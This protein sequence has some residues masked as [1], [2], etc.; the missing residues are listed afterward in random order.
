[1]KK[2]ILFI[3]VSALLVVAVVGTIIGYSLWIISDDIGVKPSNVGEHVVKQFLELNC[4]SSREYNGKVQLPI[5]DTLD[6]SELTYYYKDSSSENYTICDDSHG[7]ITPGTYNIMVE[8]NKSDNETVQITLDNTFSISPRSL[9]VEWIDTKFIFDGDIHRPTYSING[10]LIDGDDCQITFT[11]STPNPNQIGNYEASLE[12]IGTD[13]DYYELICEPTSFSI[14]SPMQ[15]LSI[16]IDDSSNFATYNGEEQGPEYNVYLDTIGA[17]DE[18]ISSTLVSDATVLISTQKNGETSTTS[19]YPINYGLYNITYNATYTDDDGNMYQADK[20][21]KQFMIN[22]K[23][24]TLEWNYETPTYDG[25][26]HCPVATTTQLVEKD[27]DCEIIVRGEQINAGE[28]YS[29]LALIDDE[30]VRNNYRISNSLYSFSIKQRPIDNITAPSFLQAFIYEG[31]TVTLS[32][33]GSAAGLNGTTLNVTFTISSNPK[34]IYGSTDEI[35]NAPV[36]IT[37]TPENK[38]YASTSLTKEIEMRPVTYISG[39]P[40]LYYGTVEKALSA[41]VSGKTVYVIPNLKNI[42]NSLHEIKVIDTCTVKTGVSLILPYEGEKWNI[43][44]DNEITSTGLIDTNENNVKGNRKILLSLRENANIIVQEAGNLYVG[45]KFGSSGVNGSYCEI[46]LGDNTSIEVDGKL[47]CYGYIKED[48]V[49]AKNANQDSYKNFYQNEFDCNRYIRIKDGGCFKSIIAIYDIKGGSTLSTLRANKIF[50]MNKFDFSNIQT[51]LE[52]QT[53]A[54]MYA[55]Y[56][57]IVA[58]TSIN[59][60]IC[61]VKPESTVRASSGSAMFFIKSGSLCFEYCPTN[62]LYTNINNALTRIYINGKVVQG[63]ISLTISGIS[64]DTKDMFLPISYRLNIFITSGGSYTTDYKVK[65]MPGS[66]LKILNGG[67]VSINST[68][69]FYKGNSLDQFTSSDGVNYENKTD[70]VLI[71][72]GK[73]EL[74]SNG[75]IGAYIQTEDTTGSAII[76]LTNVSQE[77]LSATSNE[78]TGNKNIPLITSSG[79][80]LDG[81]NIFDFGLKAGEVYTSYDTLPVWTGTPLTSYTISVFVEST[82]FIHDLYNYSIYTSTSENGNNKT[83]IVENSVLKEFSVNC[84]RQTYVQVVVNDASNT[85]I[86]ENEIAYSS[87]TWYIVDNNLN[88][89]IQPAEGYEIKYALGGSSGAGSQ[90]FTI[91]YGPASGNLNKTFKSTSYSGSIILPTNNYFTIEPSSWGKD[92]YTAK[93]IKTTYD[94]NKVATTTTLHNAKSKWSSSPYSLDGDYSFTI[95]DWS[96]TTCLSSGTLVTLANGQQK[97][98]DD[99]QIGD[100][101]LVFNHETG[102]W[103]Y[104]PIL[105]NVH[106]NEELIKTNVINLRFNDGKILRI[107]QDHALFDLDLNKYVYINESNYEQYLNHSFTSIEYINGEIITRESKLISV[108]ITNEEIKVYNPASV[109]HLNLVA[110]NVLTLSSGMVNFFDYTDNMKY[111]EEKMEAD[112]KQYGL[113]TYDDFKD[114]V[115]LEVFNAFPFKYFKVA[116]GKGLITFDEIIILIEFYNNSVA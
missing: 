60:E 12:L 2:K 18:I 25:E 50:P 112:I 40:K 62:N 37:A 38:N 19:S 24:I 115:S 99:L 110:N 83:T 45:G 107:I 11:E 27:Q 76:D 31:E 49:T 71:N 97:K 79:S 13:K 43:S 68:I 7:P 47:Y 103:D 87:S 86:N 22:Q 77:S 72:N 94:E 98:V 14:K 53:G 65:F 92:G 34:P 85:I 75:K 113:Y 51:Y 93:V 8:Y 9:E 20:I 32:S 55:T 105:V 28:N 56:H 69:I 82:D 1:M 100:E 114:Y 96:T 101:V 104:A 52:L 29:A 106:A 33:D 46:N 59:E 80:F 73:I 74:T 4:S 88:F 30:S 16:K 61:I 108:Y 44:G 66:L 81:E 21:T 67:E 48:S 35:Y 102:K 116:V 70:A 15:L 78:G 90:T 64:I 89:I 57:S 84:E 54:E 5:H 17:N 6:T 109:W 111:D 63:S 42:D 36:T 95:T 39:S 41:A 91:K 10:S 26:S 58:G 3:V 23:E